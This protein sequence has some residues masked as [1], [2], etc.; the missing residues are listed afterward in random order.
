MAGFTL[1]D[2]GALAF[3]VL[4]WLGYNLGVERHPAAQKNT[5][6]LSFAKTGL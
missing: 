2:L 4:A 1:L 5:K 3:F 6:V